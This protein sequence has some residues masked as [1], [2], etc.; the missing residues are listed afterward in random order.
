MKKNDVV[1]S[2]VIGELVA[3]YFLW[4]FGEL[5]SVSV[6]FGLPQG[7]IFWILPISF[8]ILA[9]AGLWIA[10][11]LGKKI[12]LIFQIAKYFLTGAFVTLVDLG[13][14]KFLMAAS[15]IT[16]GIIYSVFKGTSATIAFLTKFFGAKAWVFEKSG[17]EQKKE[18]KI[19]EFGSFV[20]VSVIGIAINVGAAS[21]IVNMIPPQAGL[22]SQSWGSIGG[23]GAAFVSYLWNFFGYKYFVFKK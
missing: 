2:A 17:K 15:G 22:S 3:I 23:I 21:F 4:A 1:V 9:V 13:I 16:S 10:Y 14:L 8:P 5:N 18:E 12:K 7:S 6:K 20:V 19:V 11:I